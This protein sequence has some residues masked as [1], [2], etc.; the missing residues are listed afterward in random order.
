MKK[1]FCVAAFLCLS[2]FTKTFAGGPEDSLGLSKEQLKFIDSIN[3][4]MNWQTGKISIG[5][6]IAILNIPQGF[7][8]LN[9]EQ[10]KFVLHDVWGNPPRE[11]VWGMIF[12]ESGDIWSDSSFAFIVS[13][14]E[15][16]FVKD[17]DADDINYNDMLK[18]MQDAEKEV[19]QERNKLGYESI[20]IV[21]WAQAPYYDKEAK[22]LHWAKEIHFGEDAG[23]TLNYDVRVLGRKGVLSLNAI[24]NIE[25]LPMVKAS[26]ADVLKIP[27]FTDGNK[28]SDFNESTD[29]VAEYGLGALVAGGVLAKSG[30][31]A[32]IG[33]FLAA[34]WKFI[35]I[36]VVA[37]VA[38]IKKFFNRRKEEDPIEEAE[39][40]TP[41]V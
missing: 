40:A 23:N 14:D 34:A 24:S 19:N 41:E 29:K 25:N 11:D 36:G 8:Y 5:S 13:F 9:P 3:A 38:A 18:Q 35:A 12:P 21:R 27:Q 32:A 15:T 17:K 10:S 6:G 22:V 20:H 1:L 28:Y 30:A 26:I 37:L 33:K 39:V 7:K 4:S 2:F 16:G 31:F